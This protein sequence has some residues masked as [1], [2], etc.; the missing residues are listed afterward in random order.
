[1][2]SVGTFWTRPNVKERSAEKK[3]ACWTFTSNL[4]DKLACLLP[5]VKL[6]TRWQLAV[7]QLNMKPILTS[8]IRASKQFTKRKTNLQKKD[9]KVYKIIT[10]KVP[11]HLKKLILEISSS[12][13]SFLILI[14]IWVV[15]LILISILILVFI[16]S[17]LIFTLLLIIHAHPRPNPKPHS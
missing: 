9:T 6:P 11:Q 7:D 15:L 17:R 8:D 16:L 3:W 5:A 14:L 13:S 12:S 4:T 1:M 10:K 2:Q